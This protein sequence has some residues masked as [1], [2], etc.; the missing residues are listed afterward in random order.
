MNR[1]GQED[2]YRFA[3]GEEVTSTGGLRAKLSRPLD[4][5]VISDHAEMYGL[6][7]QLLE[8]RP[9]GARNRGRQALVLRADQRRHRPHLRHRN[10]DRRLAL[11]RRAADRRATPRSAT[12]GRPTRRWPTATTTPAASSRSSASSGPR[13]AAT[14]CTATCFSAA[15]P[16]VAEPHRALL[17]VRQ[18]EPRGPLDLHWRTSRRAPASDVLAIPH[19]GNLSQRPDVHGRELRR[20]A[21]DRR[22]RREARPHTSR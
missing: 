8:R 12:P 15:T 7:P 2:A 13:S 17:A 18:Q 14:T 1:L 22:A 10:G 6:M 16:S 5:L 19:N 3:R 11:R 9:R 20:Q 21:A 4:F